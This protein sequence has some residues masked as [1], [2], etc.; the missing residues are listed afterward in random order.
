MNFTKYFPK[1]VR[2]LSKLAKSI[3]GVPINTPLPPPK[4]INE[5]TNA[6]WHMLLGVSKVLLDIVGVFESKLKTINVP[7]LYDTSKCL[8][9]TNQKSRLKY[10][11][12][13]QIQ[14]GGL[15]RV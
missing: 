12:N 15:K 13:S 6:L 2:C 3:Q 14:N 10:L 5:F 8:K 1:T 9:K 4:L 11:Y 7:L